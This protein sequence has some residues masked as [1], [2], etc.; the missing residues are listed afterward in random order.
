MH[1]F[2]FKTAKKNDAKCQAYCGAMA[3][4]QGQQHEQLV[5]HLGDDDWDIAG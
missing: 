2:L 4:E 5:T 1:Q 3:R